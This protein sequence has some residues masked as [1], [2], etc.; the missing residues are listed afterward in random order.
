MSARFPIC[1]ECGQVAGGHMTGCPETR[2]AG[3]DETPLV[4]RSC[5]MSETEVA[6]DFVVERAGP[7]CALCVCAEDAK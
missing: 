5:G 3:A 2:D 6:G 1:Q 4:C 7:I